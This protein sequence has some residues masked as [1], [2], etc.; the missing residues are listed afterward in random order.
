LR[1]PIFRL[2]HHAVSYRKNL[3]PVGAIVLVV[4]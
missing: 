1:N 3:S 4:L 2:S